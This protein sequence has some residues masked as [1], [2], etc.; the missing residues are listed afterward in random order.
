MY[1][2]HVFVYP[3]SFASSLQE[4]FATE[5]Q[6]SIASSLQEGFATEVQ[7]SFASSLQEGF[8]TEVQQSK[9]LRDALVVTSE[10]KPI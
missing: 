6:Q 3:F 2:A 7:Q 1:V 5:V 10:W 4:G 9:G 8:A